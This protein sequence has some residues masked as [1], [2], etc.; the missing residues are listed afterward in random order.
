[1][2][3]SKCATAPGGIPA[4]Y[5]EAMMVNEPNAFEELVNEAVITAHKEF[6]RWAIPEKVEDK[7]SETPTL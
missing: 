4:T 3:H 7:K 6:L 5:L 1:V 2:Y